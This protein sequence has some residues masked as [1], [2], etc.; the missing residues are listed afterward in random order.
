MAESKPAE[1]TMSVDFLGPPARILAQLGTAARTRIAEH[2][3]ETMAKYGLTDEALAKPYARMPHDMG[4][5]LGEYLAEAYESTTSSLDIASQAQ[6]GDWGLYG[7]LTQT[8]PTVGQSMAVAVDYVSLLHDGAEMELVLEGKLATLRHRLRPGLASPRLSN[9]LVVAGYVRGSQLS[10]GFVAPPLEVH[11]MHPVPANLEPYRQTFGCPVY[12][13]MPHNA[14]VIP[15]EALGVPLQTADESLHRILR[16][17]A[18]EV[19]ARLPRRRTFTNEVR[20]LV[21][22]QM[23]DGAPGLAAIATALSVSERTLRRRLADEGTSLSNIIEDLRRTE[24]ARLL[25]KSNMSVSEIAFQLGFAQ[26]PALHRAFRR[27]FG[28]APLEYRRAGTTQA[29]Q[30]LLGGRPRRS[31]D[32]PEDPGKGDGPT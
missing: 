19:L 27:W 10:L 6:F 31:P 4:I 3:R 7:Y 5:E 17:H 9:E 12:C 28:V 22:K 25:T 23:A 14:I 30:A 29:V 21:L 2:M 16:I 11:F 8:A 1:A 15:R 24:A 20:A 26:P 32:D 18:D 13:S